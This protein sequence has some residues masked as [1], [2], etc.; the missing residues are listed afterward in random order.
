MDMTAF[1]RWCCAN[2]IWPAVAQMDD[3]GTREPPIASCHDAAISPPGLGIIDYME[4]H[5]LI[6][7]AVTLALA[8]AV[9]SILWLHHMRWRRVLREQLEAGLITEDQYERMR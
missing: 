4:E 2:I 5:W 8:I 9:G 6:V 7:L 1:K 3:N